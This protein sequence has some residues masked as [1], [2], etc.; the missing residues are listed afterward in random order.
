MKARKNRPLGR[1]RCRWED[2]TKVDVREKGWDGVAW[3][4][5]PQDKV[6]LRDIV[7]PI[8]NFRIP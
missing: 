4:Y 2:N 6:Q 7:K 1:P 3:I 5:L 8:I